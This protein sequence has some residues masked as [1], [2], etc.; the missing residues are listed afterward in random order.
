[1]VLDLLLLAP[2]RRF[3]RTPD[4]QG[5]LPQGLKV[6]LVENITSV[7]VVLVSLL[8]RFVCSTLS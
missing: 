2:A 1:M 5:F 4:C 3:G 7:S 8:F 6:F